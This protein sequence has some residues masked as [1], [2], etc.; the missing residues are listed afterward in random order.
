MKGFVYITAKCRLLY[1]HKVIIRTGYQHSY[2][3][4]LLSVRRMRGNFSL[5]V[6]F[7]SFL[8]SEGL[9]YSMTVVW[10]TVWICIETGCQT[11]LSTDISQGFSTGSLKHLPSFKAWRL[12]LF[13]KQFAD[14]KR[15]FFLAMLNRA[16]RVTL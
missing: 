15:A 10:K 13:W 8:R 3:L 6:S 14:L 9:T 5:K 7:M 12:G 16:P 2:L 1:Q 11:H 4:I